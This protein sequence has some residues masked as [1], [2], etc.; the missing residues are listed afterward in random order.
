MPPASE[1]LRQKKRADEA[2]A[3]A[4]SGAAAQADNRPP[5]IGARFEGVPHGW[6]EEQEREYVKAFNRLPPAPPGYV[7]AFKCKQNDDGSMSR[8]YVEVRINDGGPGARAPSQREMHDAIM[9]AL[10]NGAEFIPLESSSPACDRAGSK[11][12]APLQ[13]PEEEVPAPEERGAAQAIGPRGSPAARKSE[14]KERMRAKL[15]KKKAKAPGPAP[16]STRASASSTGPYDRPAPAATRQP[17]PAPPADASPMEE[18]TAQ[19]GSDLAGLLNT[20]AA[21]GFGEH[22]DLEEGALEGCIEVARRIAE[23][24]VQVSKQSG[25]TSADKDNASL[26]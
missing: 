8:G 23:K 3:A 11:F 25:N 5:V 24:E 7:R 1:E 12:R 21:M 14:Q 9:D 26:Q 18:D 17:P 20:L 22:P 10:D 19:T 2:A 16:S 4:S 6:T 15:E 13:P